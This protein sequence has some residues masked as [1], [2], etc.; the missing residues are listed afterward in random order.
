MMDPLSALKTGRLAA[1]STFIDTYMVTR[2]GELVT[3]PDT[4]EVKNEAMEVYTGK[5]KIQVNAASNETP[6]AG[7][8]QFTVQTM[9]L[10]LPVTAG[11]FQISDTVTVLASPLD[12]HRVGHQ[13][14]ITA[15]HDKT[16]ATAQR[17]KVEQVVG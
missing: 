8:H 5:G 9:S 17:L 7:G 6:E 14:R 16:F 1:Q 11:P 15:L 10:H 4:G 3:D 13:F 2:P 12:P